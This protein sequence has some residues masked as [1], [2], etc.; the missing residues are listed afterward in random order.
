MGVDPDL[1]SYT[2]LME[3]VKDDLKYSEIGG[4]YICQQKGGNWKLLTDDS[5]LAPLIEK[6]DD[7]DHPDFYLANVIDSNVQ[8]IEQKQPHVVIRPRHNV[9]AGLYSIRHFTYFFRLNI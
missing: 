4:I 7:G 3:H 2:V 5:D 8:P 1:F 9:L 6:S